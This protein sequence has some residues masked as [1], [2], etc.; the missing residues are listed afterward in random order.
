MDLVVLKAS[1]AASKMGV[2]K[3]SSAVT[4]VI[5]TPEVAQMSAASGSE[6]LLWSN[7]APVM[8]LRAKCAFQALV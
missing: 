4:H 5:G 3:V 8:P 7:H 6:A 1:I 2:Q